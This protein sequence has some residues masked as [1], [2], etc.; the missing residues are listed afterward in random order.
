[1]NKG[2]K[3]IS[4]T[5]VLSML[6]LMFS[7]MGALAEGQL[8]GEELS[9]IS[10]DS[11]YKIIVPN[12]VE[13]KKVTTEIEEEPFEVNV[14]VMEIPTANSEGLYP[15]FDVVTTDKEANFLDSYP[16]IFGQGQ[17]GNV[18]GEIKDGRFQYATKFKLIENE[19]YSFGF[20][21]NSEFSVDELYV[22]FVKGDGKA[23]EKPTEE[24]KEK[25]TDKADQA[26]ANP[27][28]SK[29]LVNGKEVAFE[30]YNID[31][32]N[33]FKLRD[34]ALAVNGTEK[35]FEVSWDN[36]KNAINLQ[37]KK[38]YTPDGTELKASD[39]PATKQAALTKSD[40]F[41]DGAVLGATAYNID[42][43]NY[44]K[45]RDIAKAIGFGVTWDD[46]ANMI[47]ID[48]KSGYIEE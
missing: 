39:K 41:I 1:M 8:K 34:M 18:D 19:I 45:L 43:N 32:N 38:A 15:I 35:N 10:K 31:G 5:L 42:G 20:Y 17:V 27:T 28:A 4:V 40:L 23:A 11:G 33:Y 16:G 14:I 3:R 7:S 9:L 36:A 26:S 22:M 46:K 13:L 24:P 47:G 12:F 30:A 21:T 25:T 2:F 48:T 37:T 6:M 29:V 44:F